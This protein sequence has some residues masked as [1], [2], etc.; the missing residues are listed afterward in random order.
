[1]LFIPQ[2]END[3]QRAH[4]Y[5]NYCFERGSPVNI[6]RYSPRRTNRQNRY[7]HCIIGIVAVATG[8]T[9]E[10]VKQNIFK[11]LVNRDIFFLGEDKFGP[12][13]RSSKDI[14][15]A[16]MSTAI[17][18]YRFFCQTELGIYIGDIEDD[19]FMTY[20]EQQIEKDKDFL[21]DIQ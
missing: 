19:L 2:S 14:S 11:L 21:Y 13:L 15:T 9:L 20:C 1:M 18:R 5:V 3:K 8:H 17:S 6:T 12:K 7:M 10:E 4:E 16:L